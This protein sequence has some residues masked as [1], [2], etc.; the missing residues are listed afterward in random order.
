MASVSA[1][2]W[3]GTAERVSLIRKCP[4]PLEVSLIGQFARPR[5]RPP[6][7]LPRPSGADGTGLFL[8]L[9]PPGGGRFLNAVCERDGSKTRR[10]A[11]RY[12][13][14]QPVRLSWTGSP[15]LA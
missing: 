5:P 9:A 14:A 2:S 1:L 13:V 4:P 12:G 11:A 6:R 8:H 7:R 3:P 10:M 15:V